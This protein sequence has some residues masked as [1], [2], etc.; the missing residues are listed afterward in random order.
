MMKKIKIVKKKRTFDVND[1]LEK[2]IFSENELK[3]I[4]EK[5]DYFKM[6]LEKNLNGKAEIFIGG[7]YA[8]GTIVKKNHVD[9]D[10]FV[11][12]S[13][14][15][16][17]SDKLK[18]VL[19]KMK[20]KFS[21][22]HGSR[23]YYQVKEDIDNLGNSSFDNSKFS[24]KTIL[25]ESN[26]AKRIAYKIIYEIVPIFKIEKAS[27]AKNIT[28]ISPLHVQW[29]LSKISRDEKL[30]KEIMLGK[31]FCYG[32]NCYG[33]ES[34]ISGF[35]GYALEVLI[36]YYK[37]FANFLKNAVKWK[38]G[39]KKIIIDPEKYYKNE[40]EIL[41]GLNKSK[42]FGPLILIDP[43]QK[44]RN[45]CAALSKETL[46]LFIE[47]AKKFLKKPSE[48]FFYKK[49]I[50]IKNLKSKGKLHIITSYTNKDKIDVIGA[51]LKK[52]FDFLAYFSEKEGF[53]VIKREIEFDENAK[54]ATFYFVIKPLDEII[55]KGPPMY[56]EQKH[57]QKFRKKWVNAFEEK[58]KLFAKTTRR[59]NSFGDLIKFVK[60]D[61]V[62]KQMGITGVELIKDE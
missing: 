34:Y 36:V 23:D 49:L 21:E 39:D 15:E 25:G 13:S 5:V 11:V 47:N 9:I 22:V 59:F 54:E 6:R 30:G 45:V 50:N 7:S 3:E 18:S 29:L 28:D 37:G 26:Q 27:E 52:F 62:M 57:I 35:S 14:N 4:R 31:S 17:I 56:I 43:V 48:E 40:K 41:S 12:F 10:I 46:D 33:A 55:V 20:I 32:T 16:K 44:E 60:K 42:I 53:R 61:R 58:G 19:K 2:I 8:K 38:F 1:V 51:K 24:N